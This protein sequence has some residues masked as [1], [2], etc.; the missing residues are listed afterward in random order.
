MSTTRCFIR[1]PE[2][3]SVKPGG[4]GFHPGLRPGERHVGVDGE[5]YAGRE[6]TLV[7][8]F[9]ASQSDRL[10][11]TQPP[12]ESAVL[13]GLAVVIDDAVEPLAADLRQRAVADDRRI[14][15]RNHALVVPAVGGPQPQLPL[16]QLAGVQAPVERMR[17]PVPV[18]QPAQCGGEFLGIHSVTRAASATVF[19]P[20]W[21]VHNWNPARELSPC[22]GTRQ[23]KS[24][25]AEAR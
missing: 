8:D 22:D 17:S 16:V 12:L 19:Y 3:I 14:L 5:P 23:G 6:M 18:R 13:A 24:R 25:M 20:E 15:L 1:W 10:T 2:N 7:E 21:N 4:N 9:L 11:Q